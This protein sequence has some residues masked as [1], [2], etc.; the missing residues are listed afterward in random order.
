MWWG[1]LVVNG[2]NLPTEKNTYS[3]YQ[4]TYSAS[5][6]LNCKQVHMLQMPLLENQWGKTWKSKLWRTFWGSV[7]GKIYFKKS[8][9]TYLKSD[10]LNRS[11]GTI[12]K[13]GETTAF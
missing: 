11:S 4:L 8:K 1:T 3:E 2:L 9:N 10:F 12:L 5:P 7:K 6:I 13:N